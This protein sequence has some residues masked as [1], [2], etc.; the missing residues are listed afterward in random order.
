MLIET[1]FIIAKNWNQ[2]N[3]LQWLNKLWNF[4]II[5]YYSARKRNKFLIDTAT[6]VNLKALFYR[7]EISFKC[8]M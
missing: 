2:P 8:C 6:W 4:H 5:E 7:K 3:V 1:L